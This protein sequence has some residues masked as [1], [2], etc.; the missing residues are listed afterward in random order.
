LTPLWLPKIVAVA[1][2]IVY[3]LWADSGPR[4]KV[5]VGAVV[6]L[7]LIL[8][9]AGIYTIPWVLGLLLQ[10]GVSIFVL[11]HFRSSAA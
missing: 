1:C 9:R 8:D 2:G 3:L 10:V 4:S 5:V 6:A 11:L 7:S